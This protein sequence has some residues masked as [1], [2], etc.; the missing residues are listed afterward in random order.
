MYSV[1]LLWGTTIATFIFWIVEAFP[2]TEEE[3][4]TEESCIG[5][6]Y[7]PEEDDND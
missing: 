6:T 2:E 4:E 3:E 7:E 5:F 1:I